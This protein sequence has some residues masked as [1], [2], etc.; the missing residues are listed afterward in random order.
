MDKAIMRE[1]IYNYRHSY[2]NWIIGVFKED[3]HI[4]FSCDDFECYTGVKR[5]R[6]KLHKYYK[7]T[8]I[9]YAITTEDGQFYTVSSALKYLIRFSKLPTEPHKIAYI[10]WLNNIEDDMNTT[11]DLEPENCKLKIMLN[12]VKETNQELQ[13]E[14][15]RLRRNLKWLNMQNT[16]GNTSKR[17]KN[18]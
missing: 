8:G 9:S 2:H 12:D 10:M 7:K 17:T 18:E 15:K 16:K 14:I 13:K 5:W 11:K 6:H 3:G 1:R 4:W